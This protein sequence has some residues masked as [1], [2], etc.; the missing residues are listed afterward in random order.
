[1]TVLHGAAC[2]RKTRAGLG[3]EGGQGPI[4]FYFLM[5][6]AAITLWLSRQR[7]L[8]TGCAGQPGSARW[9]SQRQLSPLL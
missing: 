1:M 6:F 3:R 4:I 5:D 9:N 8:P 2:P 7:D